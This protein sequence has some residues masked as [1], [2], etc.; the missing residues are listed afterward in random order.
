[1]PISAQT[2]AKSSENQSQ[3]LQISRTFSAPLAK[4]V[5]IQQVPLGKSSQLL[6][7]S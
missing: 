4:S 2:G 6:F 1:L 3:A 7:A 5:A